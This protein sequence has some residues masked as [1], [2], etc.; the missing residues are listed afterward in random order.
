ML[1]LTPQIL[2]EVPFNLQALI[3]LDLFKSEEVQAKNR[4]VDP[5]R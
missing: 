5:K 4:D 2:L 3:I 1:G